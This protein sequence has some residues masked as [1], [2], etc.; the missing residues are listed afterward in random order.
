MGLLKRNRQLIADFRADTRKTD[1]KFGGR[2]L[3]LLTTTG[4]KSG[5]PRT[6]PVAYTTD[7]KRYVALASN[8]GSEQ[9]PNWYRNLLAHPRVTVEVG[10]ERF[11]ATATVAQ[12]A[13]RQRLWDQMVAVMPGFA[14]YQ[15]KMQRQ[16]PVVV[17]TRQ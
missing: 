14:D 17:L 6:S 9:H 12:G 11:E 1:G 5:E 10:N 15:A 4:A 16:I 2:A 3:L 13:E 7:G 8:G